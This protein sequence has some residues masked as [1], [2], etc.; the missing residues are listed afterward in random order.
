LFAFVLPAFVRVV[1]SFVSSRSSRCDRTVFA[2]ADGTR[3]FHSHLLFSLVRPSAK[4]RVVVVVVVV[5]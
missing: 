3:S 2:G 5:E 4:T 1:V